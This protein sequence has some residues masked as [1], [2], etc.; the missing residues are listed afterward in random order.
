MP[1]F[2]V[3]REVLQKFGKN[4]GGG[5]QP[6]PPGPPAP[7]PMFKTLFPNKFCGPYLDAF[8]KIPPPKTLL[9]RK[10]KSHMPDHM[11]VLIVLNQVKR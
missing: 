8:H 6:S 5:L 7:P 4:W 3:K 1:K 10:L 9:N 11:L 2:E